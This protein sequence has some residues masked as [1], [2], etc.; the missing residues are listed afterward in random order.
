MSHPPG[1]PGPPNWPDG[2]SPWQSPT[3]VYGRPPHRPVPAA[4]PGAEFSDGATGWRGDQPNRPRRDRSLWP[5]L[6]AFGALLLT[7][8]LLGVVGFLAP[9]WFV[10]TV[11]DAQSVQKGVEQTLRDSY[12]INGVQRVQCPSGEPVR[13]GNQFDCQVRIDGQNKVVPVSVK[14]ERGVYEVGHPK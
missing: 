7:A 5:G 2:P 4:P 11:F 1:P 3:W 13:T 8:A 9:G 6:V 12:Q 14:T 10:R